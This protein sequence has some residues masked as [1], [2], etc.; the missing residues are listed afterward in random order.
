LILAVFL[1]KIKLYKNNS[2]PGTEKTSGDILRILIYN[3]LQY[4]KKIMLL[5][6]KKPVPATRGGYICA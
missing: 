2:I 3:I 5:G 4:N 1:G 6:K